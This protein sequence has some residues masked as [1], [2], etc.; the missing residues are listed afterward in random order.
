MRGGEVAL[1]TG[2]MIGMTALG[3]SALAGGELILFSDS[4]VD[5]FFPSG[6]KGA[7]FESIASPTW[8]GSATAL[9]IKMDEKV[10]PNPGVSFRAGKAEKFIDISKAQEA[11]GALEFY[12]NTSKPTAADLILYLYNSAGEVE[13]TKKASLRKYV[14]LDGDPATWQKVSMP[15][16]DLTGKLYEQFSGLLFR[17]SAIPDAEFYLDEITISKYSPGVAARASAGILSFRGETDKPT[18]IYNAG[19]KMVFR[20]QLLADSKPVE[21]KKLKWTREG[22]DGKTESGVAVSSTSTPL[23]IETSCDKPGFVHIVVTVVNNDGEPAM[24]GNSRGIVFEGGAGVELEKIEGHPEPKDFDAFWAAQKAKL[25]QVPL[26][27]KQVEVPSSNPKVRVFDVKVTCA[28]GKPV[29]GYF[30]KPKDAVAKSLPAH[31]GFLGY[32]VSSAKPDPNAVD[33]IVFN[34]NTHGIEN[35]KDPDYYANLQ[36]GILKKYAFDNQENANPE[37]AYFNGMMLRVLRALEFIKSQPEWDGRHLVVAGGSQ[38]GLQALVAAGLDRDVTLCRANKPWCC[39]LGGINLGRLRGWRPDYTDALRYFDAANHAKRITCETD[40]VA[41]LG[42]Y[43]CPPSGIM[44]LYNNIKAPKKITY[45]QG[46]THGYSPPNPQTFTLSATNAV[47]S[48]ADRAK[49]ET[50]KWK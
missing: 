35:G 10:E 33:R 22:D 29:S 4:P 34:I 11:G 37:T 31:V 17:F 41:G 30:S 42:D 46:V 36:K 21:G 13:A 32:G 20:V 45:V 6:W 25:A 3:Y 14:E 12:V 23:I 18:A 2:M 8:N 47:G 19:E 40:L 5:G 49:T 48:G 28:G 27:A 39:D 44:V 1:L 43:V 50:Q 9:R 24:D 38:G 7:R 15:L 26:E 16:K